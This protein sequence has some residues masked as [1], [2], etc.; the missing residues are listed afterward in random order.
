M[1]AFISQWD[2][3]EKDGTISFDDFRE[4]YHDLGSLIPDDVYF[5]WML[6]S[7]WKLGSDLYIAQ[8]GQGHKGH[9]VSS[10]WG[11][12]VPVGRTGEAQQA[13]GGSAYCRITNGMM[14]PA[15][16]P[17]PYVELGGGVG[18]QALIAQRERPASS[19]AVARA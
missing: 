16:S 19:R 7:A 15:A 3:F 4:D 1:G 17:A 5:E 12:P 2:V 11:C 18:T 13:V 9:N 14:S 6:R 8:D 10:A